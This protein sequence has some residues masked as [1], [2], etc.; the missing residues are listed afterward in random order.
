MRAAMAL[1]AE[2]RPK[3]SA[4]KPAENA[5]IAY[6]HMNL[7][8]QGSVPAQTST[9]R[10]SDAEPHVR[11]G[12]EE[13]ILRAKQRC[14]LY[15]PKADIDEHGRDVRFVPK[16][17][18]ASLIDHLGGQREQLFWHVQVDCS[19][20]DSRNVWDGQKNRVPVTARL[21]SSSRS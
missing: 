4:I 21:K 5:P 13:D 20:T 1:I 6:R 18:I 2:A 8:N 17:D 15:P 19:S 11:F 16:A 12:S 10:R 9:Q 14:P 3:E 7:P